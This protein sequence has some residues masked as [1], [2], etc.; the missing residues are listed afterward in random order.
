VLPAAQASRRGH[1]AQRPGRDPA[2]ASPRVTG[3]NAPASRRGHE[4]TVVMIATDVR[5]RLAAIRQVIVAPGN[6]PVSRRG[7]GAACGPAAI[8]QVMT[9]WLFS[10]ATGC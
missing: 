4:T 2:G 9:T 7:H 5:R 6:A 1:G 10:P 8:R 3:R